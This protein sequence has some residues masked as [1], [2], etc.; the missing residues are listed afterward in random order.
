MGFFEGKGR[1]NMTRFVEQAIARAGLSSVMPARARGDIDSV[2]VLLASLGEVDLLTIGAVADA[3]RTAEAGDV[4]RVHSSP[5][6]AD[7]A[8]VH[9]IVDAK[10]ELA[11][12]RQ[13]ALARVT[14]PAASRIGVDW[15]R[16]GLELAQVALGFGA[17]DLTGPI[18]RKSG[19]LISEDE[20][21]KVKGQGMVQ[22]AALRRREIAALIHNAKRSC[23]FA[24][25]SLS[26]GG[27]GSESGAREGEALHA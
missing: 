2:R 11:L 3:I 1:S 26:S 24:D 10:S 4:V 18:T 16:H 17:T 19:L 7:A 9:W 12:L 6:S 25:E 14:G 22:R 21:K 20:L 5:P 27:R 13:V 8:E 15:G 23:E